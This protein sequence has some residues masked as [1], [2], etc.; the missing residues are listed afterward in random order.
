MDDFGFITNSPTSLPHLLEHLHVAF[1]QYVEEKYAQCGLDPV[2]DKLKPP[3][4][5]DFLRWATNYL[6]AN[7]VV[8]NFAVDA[9]HGIRLANNVMCTIC[10]GEEHLHGTME[11]C[12]AIAV[13][14]GR[15]QP[16]LEGVQPTRS[17]SIF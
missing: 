15:S 7:R 14:D 2:R 11:P 5:R 3:S 12:N 10:P 9:N 4:L 6:T 17:D 13:I 16:G 1:R 8:E